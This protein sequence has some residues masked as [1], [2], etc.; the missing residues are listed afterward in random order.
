MF[1]A[2][3]P[4]WEQA[5]RETMNGELKS[6]ALVEHSKHRSH[7]NSIVSMLGTI[8]V[9]CMFSKKPC[10]KVQRTLDTQLAL[11]LNSSNSR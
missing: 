10:I 5:N 8:A 11:F 6:I 7:E 9:Y 3:S 2:G 1:P 4:L